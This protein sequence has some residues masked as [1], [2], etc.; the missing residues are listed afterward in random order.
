MFKW[1]WKNKEWLFSGAGI[2][3]VALVIQGL[4]NNKWLPLGI[5]LIVVSIAFTLVISFKKRK[6]SPEKVEISAKP[7]QLAVPPKQDKEPKELEKETIETPGSK[8]IVSLSPRDI[9]AAIDATPP[10]QR[11]D[12][13]KYYVGLRVSWDGYL[14]SANKKDQN[15]IGLWIGMNEKLPRD[16]VYAEVDITQYVELGVMNKNHPIHIEGTI[17]NID[18]WIHLDDAKLKYSL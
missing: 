10:L 16:F 2:I 4:N 9:L 11:A 8:G 7:S 13:K 14:S 12:K 3:V 1:V 18:Q 5:F 17:T 6:S 15:I